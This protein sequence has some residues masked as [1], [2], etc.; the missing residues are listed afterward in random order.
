MQSLLVLRLYY[1]VAFG[2][3]GLFLPFFTTWLQSQGLRG[4]QMSILLT[5]V[6]LL[7]LLSP[8]L[9]GLFADHLGFRGRMIRV[10]TLFTALSLSLLGLCS[11][12]FRP[13]PFALAFACFL[14]F[15]LFR[16]PMIGLAD[17]LALEHPSNYG[18]TRLMG[19]LGF[20]TSTLVGGQL[21][22]PTHPYQLPCALA[23][24]VWLSVLLA[25]FL[26]PHSSL[27]PRPAVQDA[28]E[29]LQKPAFRQLLLTVGLAYMAISAYDMCV[30]LR[31]RD[32]GASTA[33]VGNFWAL[34]TAAE[35]VL[36]YG[37]A[38]WVRRFGPGKLLTFSLLVAALRWLFLSQ[39]TSLFWI[40]ALQPL[41]AISFALFWVSAI[42]TLQRETGTHG[43]ATAQGIFS[44]ATALGVSLGMSI[45]GVLYESSGGTLLFQIAASLS[46][47]SALSASRLIRFKSAVPP[48][49]HSSAAN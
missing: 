5:L 45:W 6:P 38:P 35:I 30:S 26:P 28:R 24:A 16:G 31:L 37:A 44:S 48:L 2:A 43:M 18:R 11:Y 15:A 12:L 39:A 41:H 23:G 3:F 4:A 36:L 34:A 46:F 47:L 33:Y 40:L 29:L 49:P 21:I 42:S 7:S 20:M 19:S 25:Q 9:V 17:V 27:P 32:L 8:P 13:L 1:F 14:P 22:D 10:A